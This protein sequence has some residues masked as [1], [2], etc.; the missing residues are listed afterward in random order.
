MM[1]KFGVYPA[2]PPGSGGSSRAPATAPK[3]RSG[4]ARR[5]RTERSV[6]PFLNGAGPS[7][8]WS[9][10][11]SGGRRRFWSSVGRRGQHAAP[12]ARSARTNGVE[13][14]AWST[15]DLLVGVVESAVVGWS[16]SISGNRGG[17][18]GLPAIPSRWCCMKPCG[19]PRLGR[20]REATQFLDRT[21]RWVMALPG[22][23]E[24]LVMLMPRR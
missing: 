7:T 19:R 3:C 10:P 20:G 16:A 1:E 23:H 13:A 11:V 14:V 12:G 15:Q 17:Q 22:L 18:A 8:G 4:T 2:L 9:E 24:V 6:M 5:L 21:R